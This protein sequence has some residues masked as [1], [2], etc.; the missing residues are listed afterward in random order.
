MRTIVIASVSFWAGAMIYILFRS[1]HILMFRWINRLGLLNLVY[2]IRP[3]L[4][5]LPEWVVYSLPDGLW[6][7]S[8]CLF[9]GHVWN[10][11]LKRSF[12]FLT[13]LPIYAISNEIMQYFH[14]VSGT[15]DWKD[16]IAFFFSFALGVLYLIYHKRSLIK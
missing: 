10:Y 12:L 5:N 7:F 3:N 2:S 8:Y 15:F 11:N 6:M 16:L 9:V 1:T 14:F 13:L 4:K